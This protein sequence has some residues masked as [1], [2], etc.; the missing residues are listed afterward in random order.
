M[1]RPKT[2]PDSVLVRE[3]R[4]TPPDGQPITDWKLGENFNQLIAAQEGGDDDC[5]L[6]YHLYI[7]TWRSASWLTKWIY[8]VAHCYN[9]EQG[10]TVFFSRKPHENTIGYVVKHGNIVVKHGCTDTFITEWLNKSE[11]YRKDKDSARQRAK[12]L[13]KSFTQ[14]VYLKITEMVKLDRSLRTP[15][16]VLTHILAEYHA[17]NMVYP[18]RTIVENLIVTILTPYDATLARMFYLRSFE[19]R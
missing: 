16:Q 11:Q 17:A 12:R 3:L 5:R 9:G 8:S 4:I 14:A 19:P 18:S 7:E 6:H 15:D 2:D 1:P 10:N 13:K